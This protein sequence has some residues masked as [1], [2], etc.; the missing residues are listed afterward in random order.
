ML[1]DHHGYFPLAIAAKNGHFRVVSYLTMR[2]DESQKPYELEFNE[3]VSIASYM[4]G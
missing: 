1:K 4:V 2:I 3:A